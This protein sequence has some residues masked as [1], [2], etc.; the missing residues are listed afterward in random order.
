MSESDL[1][2]TFCKLAKRLDPVCVENLLTGSTGVGTPDV[3]L[4]N[5]AWVE[6][7]WAKAWPARATTP[8][9]VPHF[10]QEQRDWA[11]RRTDAGGCCYLLLQVGPEWFIFGYPGMLSVGYLTHE[12]LKESALTYFATKPSGEALCAALLP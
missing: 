3:N 1:R 7:K 9:R 2:Q 11:K 8:L 6:L 10:T 4:S 12:E 5:G